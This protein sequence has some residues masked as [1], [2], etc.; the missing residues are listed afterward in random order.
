MGKTDIKLAPYLNFHGNAEE[1][2]ETYR[3]ILGGRVEII[4]RYDN[5]AM[6]TRAD[7]R[8]KI[9]HASFQFGNNIIY[10]SDILSG[11]PAHSSADVALSISLSDA[12]EAGR[13]FD[14]LMEGGKVIVPFSKQ[15][16]GTSH[17]NGLDRFGVR[18]M[19]NA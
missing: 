15:F 11:L 7:D 13:I 14:A 18:W 6:K 1:A 10:A 4:Q 16:W 2:L 9:L 19:V 3:K 17:G 5:P 12:S 8:H